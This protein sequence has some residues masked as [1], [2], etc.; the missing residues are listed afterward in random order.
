MLKWSWNAGPLSQNKDATAILGWAGRHLNDLYAIAG[1]VWTRL[2]KAGRCRLGNQ[3]L[4]HPLCLSCILDYPP[5]AA[6]ASE[7]YQRGIAG[8]RRSTNT[9]LCHRARL[10]CTAIFTRIGFVLPSPPTVPVAMMWA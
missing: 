4:S 10:S 6:Q 1:C 3:A 5:R 9:S 8:F 7:A 2:D